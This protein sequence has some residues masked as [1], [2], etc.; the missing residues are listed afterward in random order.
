MTMTWPFRILTTQDGGGGGT[1]WCGRSLILILNHHNEFVMIG[2][3][4]VALSHCNLWL[5]SSQ[6]DF[7][8]EHVVVGWESPPHSCESSLITMSSLS[9]YYDRNQQEHQVYHCCHMWSASQQQEDHKI[10][11]TGSMWHVACGAGWSP[12]VHRC[13]SSLITFQGSWHWTLGS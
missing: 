2:S 13:E 7:G 8:R 6:G 1:W 10:F 9:F 5:W 11:L 12:I 3:T 4:C